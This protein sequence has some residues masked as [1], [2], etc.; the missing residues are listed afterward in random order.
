[1]AFKNDMNMMYATHDGLRRDLDHIAAITQRPQDDPKHLLRTALGWEMF[2]FFLQVHHRAEDDLLWPAMRRSLAGDAAA[3][4]LLDAMEAEHAVIDPLL[5]SISAALAD[6]ES[7]PS[8]LGE[9]TDRLASLLRAHLGH[10]EVDVLP[11]IDATV[12]EHEWSSF[13]TETGRRLGED[14]QRFFPWA[15]EDAKPEIRSAVLGVLPP[16]MALAYRDLWQPTYAALPL[17]PVAAIG[18]G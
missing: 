2:T 3:Q 10:E 15:L 14:V 9:L 1:M 13:G 12:S 6:R 8:R 5:A 17:W 11:L 16:P 18:R 4:A 7:G